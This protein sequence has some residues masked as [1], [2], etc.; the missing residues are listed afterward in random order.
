ML[1]NAEGKPAAGDLDE[2]PGIAVARCLLLRL[3]GE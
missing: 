3:N 1:L 2:A